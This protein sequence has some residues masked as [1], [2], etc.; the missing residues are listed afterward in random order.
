M[1]KRTI[2][3]V[4]TYATFTTT[5]AVKLSCGPCCDCGDKEESHEKDEEGDT[6]ILDEIEEQIDPT[7]LNL[8][9]GSSVAGP[10]ADFGAVDSSE[11]MMDAGENFD[12]IEDLESADSDQEDL[13]GA[14]GDLGV[15]EDPVPTLSE[16]PLPEVEVSAAPAWQDG[17]A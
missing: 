15:E 6:P 1:F 10:E 3:L 14:D 17:L 11:Q 2:A 4:S 12:E 16:E 9:L 8:L 13:D 7:N 5:E